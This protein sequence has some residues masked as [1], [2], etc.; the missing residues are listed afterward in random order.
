M[1]TSTDF[2]RAFQFPTSPSSVF[3]QADSLQPTTYKS[4]YPG[5]NYQIMVRS[6]ASVYTELDNTFLVT[7]STIIVYEGIE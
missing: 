5:I 7:P 2:A 1:Q 6:A 4:S 3:S